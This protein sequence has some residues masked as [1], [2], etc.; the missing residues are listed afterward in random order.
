MALFGN[1]RKKAKADAKAR[2]NE[3]GAPR[4]EGERKS[5]NKRLK[6]KYGYD[7]HFKQAHVEK[8]GMGSSAAKGDD[9]SEI[10]KMSDKYKRK[11]K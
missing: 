10:M 6:K 8:G 7:E 5:I 11:G 9:A 2:E 1:A 3:K 4:S